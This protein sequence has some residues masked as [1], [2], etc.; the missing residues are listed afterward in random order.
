MSLSQLLQAERIAILGQPQDGDLLLH[1]IA[2]LLADD[3]DQQNV[4]AA[5]LRQ[6]ERLGSTSIGHGVAIPHGRSDVFDQARAAF[7][8]LPAPVDYGANDE[9]QVDLLFALSVP[10]HF[11]HQHLQ[12]LAEIAERF[13]DESLRRALREAEDIATLHALLVGPR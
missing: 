1:T 6:R 3:A 9:E 4:I 11:S 13:S 2:G 10:A 5:S 8:R 7:V 12:I